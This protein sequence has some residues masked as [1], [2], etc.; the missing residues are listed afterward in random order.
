[1][2][3]QIIPTMLVG[4]VIIAVTIFFESKKEARKAQ[5]SQGG[6]KQS[7]GKEKTK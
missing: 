5:K 1:M 7:E 3:D 6:K 4:A 2:M